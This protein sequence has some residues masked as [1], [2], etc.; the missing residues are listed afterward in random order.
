MRL[1]NRFFGLSLVGMCILLGC[2]SFFVASDFNLQTQDHKSIAVVPIKMIFTGKIPEDWSNSDVL[3]IEDA[4][5]RSFQISLHHELLRSTKGGRRS[6][7]VK[8]QHHQK[9]V[10]M[11]E[12]QEISIRDSWHRS[13]EELAAILQVDAVV[14]ASIEKRRFLS[15]LESYGIEVAT[16][17]VNIL[18]DYYLM[19][20]LPFTSVAKE[21]KAEYSLVDGLDGS[22]LWSIS[23]VE[24]AD[25]RQP[26]NAIV[27][28][29]S[30]KAARK[31][32]YRL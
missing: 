7:S 32:P 22:T 31:F 18:T 27:D 14:I 4:E 20:W 10:T 8:I 3:E 11:L 26:S 16:H 21:I 19:P 12:Q 29:I 5:S 23:F 24:G 13:P 2:K 17:V 28:R 6:V 9:T 15:D 1:I 25:W 30:R